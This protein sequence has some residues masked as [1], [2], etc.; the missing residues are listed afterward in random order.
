[1]AIGEDEYCDVGDLWE[2]PGDLAEK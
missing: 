1:V 2:D